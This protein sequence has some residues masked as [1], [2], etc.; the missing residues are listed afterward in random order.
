MRCR[1]KHWREGRANEG[2]ALQV[3]R[4]EPAGMNSGNRAV[5]IKQIQDRC[6]AKSHA[7]G[8]KTGGKKKYWKKK[9]KCTFNETT[10][11]GG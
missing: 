10:T 6:G 1:Y 3:W 9:A 7:G 11:T 5:L 4:G 8:E 2:D